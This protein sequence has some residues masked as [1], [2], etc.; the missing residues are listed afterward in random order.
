MARG[1]RAEMISRLPIDGWSGLREIL[2]QRG[3]SVWRPGA[4]GGKPVSAGTNLYK[5]FESVWALG[6][7]AARQSASRKDS[8]LE[9]SRNAFGKGR[10]NLELLRSKKVSRI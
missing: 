7:R 4:G 9:Q 6:S 10:T 2:L 1:L 5:M 3:V 8:R